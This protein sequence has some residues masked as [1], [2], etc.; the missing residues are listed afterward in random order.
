MLFVKLQTSLS[1]INPQRWVFSAWGSPIINGSKWVV[2]F[3]AKKSS[4]I[5]HK[6]VS[7]SFTIK[8]MPVSGLPYSRKPTDLVSHSSSLSEDPDELLLPL[9]CRPPTPPPP[10]VPPP[11]FP[12]LRHPVVTV[13]V[14]G[15]D[16]EGRTS[17]S[18][19]SRSE[20]EPDVGVAQKI[21]NDLFLFLESP[22]SAKLLGTS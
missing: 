13:D 16:D 15:V 21:W 22:N 10:P 1:V 4:N 14:D 6:M 11:P 7:Q 19:D 17:R 12:T 9:R 20:V 2:H 5:I 8:I 3:H 18:W